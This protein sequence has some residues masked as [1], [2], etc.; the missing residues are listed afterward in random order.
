MKKLVAKNV[1]ELN[2]KRKEV[3]KKM[4][5]IFFLYNEICGGSGECNEIQWKEERIKKRNDSK[6]FI[7]RPGKKM[8]I[9]EYKTFFLKMELEFRLAC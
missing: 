6:F 5:A 2:E 8:S 9:T 1:M 7:M 4:S 3:E